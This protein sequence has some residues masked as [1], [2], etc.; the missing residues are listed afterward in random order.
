MKIRE[1]ALM[2]KFLLI[3]TILLSSVDA[4]KLEIFTKI[5]KFITSS[6]KKPIN[7]ALRDK[8]HPK[9]KVR[10]NKQG[11]PIF[12]KI[13]TCDM[14]LSWYEINFDKF[15]SDSSIRSKHFAICSKKLYKKTLKNS[16]LKSRFSKQQL[17]QLRLGKTPE[18]YTWHHT[19][20]KNTL[21]LV[22]RQTH[23]DTAHSGGFSIHH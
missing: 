1:G 6:P 12:D 5:T 3:L 20:K 2:L 22:D 10:Y 7:Y 4:G 8:K 15:Q 11:Y 21:I 18:N 9:T 17:R 13:D 14:R 23:A 19:P 16:A